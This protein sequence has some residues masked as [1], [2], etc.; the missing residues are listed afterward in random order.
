MSHLSFILFLGVR[1]L[2]SLCLLKKKRWTTCYEK[3]YLG[4]NEDCSPGESTSDSSEVLKEVGGKVNICDFGE[5]GV[6][7]IKHL[8]YERFSASHVELKS[9]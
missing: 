4:Q 9:P 3:L 5:G 6:H 1:L 7:V 8:S 2:W